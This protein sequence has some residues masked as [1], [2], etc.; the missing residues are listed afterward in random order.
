M[1][2]RLDNIFRTTFRQTESADTWMGIRRE[3]PRGDQRRKKNEEEESKKK[4]EWEDD[5]VV[6][7]SALR[8]FLSSLIAP[9][10]PLLQTTATTVTEQ[11]SL[12]TQQQRAHTAANAYQNTARHASEQSAAPPAPV[13]KTSTSQPALSQDENRAIYQLLNNLDLLQQNG[14]TSLHIR[15]EGSFLESLTRAAE[16]QLSQVT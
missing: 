14:I 8:Q 13:V 5:T 2:S 10:S 6:S 12:T 9:E 1:D 15:K 16:W 4:P 11:T 3:E 7:I